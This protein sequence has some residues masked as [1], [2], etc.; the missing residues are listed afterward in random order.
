MFK[1]M[2]FGVRQ[3]QVEINATKSFQFSQDFTD[4]NTQSHISRETS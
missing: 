3:T 1:D 2:S 4:F